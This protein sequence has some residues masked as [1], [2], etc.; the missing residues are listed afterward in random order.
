MSQS[1]LTPN[2][3]DPYNQQFYNDWKQLQED[4]GTYQTDAAA[5]DKARN[6]YSKEFT[7]LFN[8]SKNPEV[9]FLA[10]IVLFGNQGFTE[11]DQGLGVQG[12]ALKIQSD[13]TQLNND[14]Q[15]L[16]DPNGAGAGDKMKVV[17]VAHDLD[18]MLNLLGDSHMA[19]SDDQAWYHTVQQVLGT[20]NA[21]TGSS[22]ID[23]QYYSL[24]MDIH[25]NDPERSNYNPAAA[26]PGAAGDKRSYHYD[27][28]DPNYITNFA[29]TATAMGQQADPDQAAEAF[30]LWTDGE[31]TVS[32]T[33]QSLSNAINAILSNS[34]NTIKTF[35]SF[36][37]NMMHAIMD[38]VK[39]SIQNQTKG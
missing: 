14:L 22:L 35:Q 11:L 9:V 12:D 17:T 27:P 25:L 8:N 4:A 33:T 5:A 7:N 36:V 16:S 38:V 19:A 37:A 1:P 31:N 29:E 2:P 28:N 10:L 18:C 30:K 20:G 13:M 21:G 24:R 34:T 32:T 39:G 15:S 23:Q 6:D 3:N 26:P